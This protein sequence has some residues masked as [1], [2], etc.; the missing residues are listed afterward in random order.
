MCPSATA[1]G[2]NA[3]PLDLPALYPRPNLSSGLD[4]KAENGVNLDLDTRTGWPDDLRLFLERFPREAWPSH[5][6]LGERIRFWL[7]VHNGFREIGGILQSATVDLR[8]QRVT[9]EYFR[10][11]FAPR[12]RHL[13]SHL[14]THHHIEDHEYFPVLTVAEPRLARGFDVLESDHDVIHTTIATLAEAANEFMVIES[15]GRD[16]LR[17]VGDR[18]ADASDALIRQLM[19]HLD[20]EEDLIVP[21]VLDRGEG[22]LGI[23]W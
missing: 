12:L 20:D 9:P 10:S 18:Y 15:A 2:R 3:L 7:G 5:A 17:S 8:E 4:S 11:W 6:N 23:A 13:L 22:P 14:H 1:A 19:R 21:L 16:R